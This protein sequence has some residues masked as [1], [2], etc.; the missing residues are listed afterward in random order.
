MKI[1]TPIQEINNVTRDCL[2]SGSIMEESMDRSRISR[3]KS[4]KTKCA[5]SNYDDELEAVGFVENTGPPRKGFSPSQ[6]EEGLFNSLDSV[7]TSS[8]SNHSFLVFEDWQHSDSDSD[9]CGGS[10]AS[11]GSNDEDYED[12]YR[13]QQNAMAKLT[14]ESTKPR[15]DSSTLTLQ[16]PRWMGRQL[17]VRGTLDLIAE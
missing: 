11:L 5:I 1:N 10:F 14:L 6:N 9:D 4:P 3:H 16:T 8:S 2:L 15:R 13:E 17:S 7:H 12:A